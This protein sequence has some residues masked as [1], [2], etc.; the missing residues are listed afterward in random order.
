MD[1]ELNRIIYSIRSEYDIGSVIMY[2]NQISWGLFNG[3]GTVRKYTL[4]C[5]TNLGAM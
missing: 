5:M 4:H 1:S 3:L 2:I